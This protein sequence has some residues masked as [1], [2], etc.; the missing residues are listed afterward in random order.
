MERALHLDAGLWQN[1]RKVH[2]GHQSSGGRAGRPHAG[3]PERVAGIWPT[4]GQE[5]KLVTHVFNTELARSC[6]VGNSDAA[7]TRCPLAVLVN[8]QVTR[9]HLNTE[10]AVQF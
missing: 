2:V 8:L 9:L 6:H 5:R 10:S 4:S 3:G 7:A 1:Q